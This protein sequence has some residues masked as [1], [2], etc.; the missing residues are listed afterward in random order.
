MGPCGTV[1]TFSRAA[2]Q[3]TIVLRENTDALL[4]IL[5]AVVSDPLFA[6]NMTPR[7]ARNR[8]RADNEGGGEDMELENEAAATKDDKMSGDLNEAGIRALARIQEKLQG[9][10]DGS[11]GERQGV[12][13]Q[14]QMLIN[15]ARDEDNLCRLFCG[16]SA[17]V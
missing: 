17:F 11:S 10:E 16:W 5:S 2:E 7:E 15:A 12:E 4:T 14:V 1:G 13:G 9:Y 3:A 6:W 8:Q